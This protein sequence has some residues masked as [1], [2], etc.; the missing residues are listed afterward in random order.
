MMPTYSVIFD[1]ETSYKTTVVARDEAAAER[2]AHEL[3]FGHGD[4]EYYKIRT[5]DSANEI[6]FAC[7]NVVIDL[8][9]DETEAA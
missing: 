6:Y 2:K 3:I 8:V 1:T 5:P 7:E 4:S 9:E